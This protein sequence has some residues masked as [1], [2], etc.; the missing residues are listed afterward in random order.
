MQKEIT[1]RNHYKSDPNAKNT[2]IFFLMSGFY[3]TFDSDAIV[4]SQLFWLKI[5]LQEWLETVWFLEKST[6]YFDRLEDAGY[7]YAALQINSD[8]N[9]SLLRKYS[10]NKVLDLSIPF[11]NFQ[12]LL[13]DILRIYE[14]YSTCLRLI[15]PLDLPFCN[16]ESYNDYKTNLI[17]DYESKEPGQTNK[18]KSD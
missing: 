1:H 3:K 6:S 12:W 15:Q 17:N 11:E 16:Q 13:N 5:T 2:L 18:Q 14:R 10:W 4:V 8:W 9:V 7:S